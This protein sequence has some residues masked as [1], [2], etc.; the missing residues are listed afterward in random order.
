MQNSE[1]P[2]DPERRLAS[3]RKRPLDGIRV[4]DLSRVLAG[5]WCTQNLADLGA[6]VIKIE[7]PETGDDTRS[8]GPPYLRDAAG[9][10]T[11]ESAYFLCANRNKQSVAIDMASPEGAALIREFAKSS[12]V[13]V[14]NFKVGGLKKYGLDYESLA[15]INPRIVYCSITGFGQTGP[16]AQRAGYDFL[17]QGMG[18]LMSITGE[19]D[20]TP[21]GGPEKVGVAVT[22]LMAGMYAT[23]G[24]LAALLERA[25]S[26]QGQHL[27]IALHDCQLAMLANQSMNYLTTGVAPKRMGNAHP[28]IVPYQTFAA[29][30]GH[31]ILACGNDSQFRAICNAMNLP[32]LALDSRFATNSGRSVN[33]LELLPQLSAVFLTRT[34]DAWI[35]AFE[36]C[37][38]PCG[39][40]NDV[41]QAFS[42][43]QAEARESVRMV[44]HPV[45]GVAPTVASPL[46]LS[47][48]PVEYNHAPPMLGEHT[49]DVLRDVLGIS[50]EQLNELAQS[51][52]V[53]R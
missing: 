26:G 52:V 51:G 6:E 33:R 49:A 14:E 45:A 36:A 32:E 44:A 25:Q 41:A 50:D 31:L 39:P 17:I 12:D 15:A 13:V 8:W 24:I 42:S 53:G 29:S 30:D 2:N 47:A 46:R 37:G 10:N 7:R 28:N 40:I 1:R 11:S 22:D 43:P 19:P 38:V 35:D 16:L 34:R 18:G 4:L 23:T 3:D 21:G 5:P 48:T 9:E 20:S 27:D